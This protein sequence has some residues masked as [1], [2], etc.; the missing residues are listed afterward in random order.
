MRANKSPI[1]PILLCQFSK[2]RQQI[3][4][5]F[6]NYELRICIIACWKAANRDAQAFA[7]PL[8]WDYSYSHRK[9]A[10]SHP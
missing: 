3:I 8:G 10:L 2:I 5:D 9:N 6:R 4:S 1:S 7:A